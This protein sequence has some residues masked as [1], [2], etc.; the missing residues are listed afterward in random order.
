MNNQVELRLRY[1]DDEKIV[2]ELVEFFGWVA[3]PYVQKEEEI[4]A[5]AWGD[6]IVIVLSIVGEWAAERYVLDPLANRAEEWWKGITS[7]WRK[8]KSRRRF[9]VIVEFKHDA[10]DLE[11]EISDTSD[12]ETLKQVWSYVGRAYQV[13]Q[14]ARNQGVFL[15]KVRIL[16]DGT[17]DVLVIGYES[18]RPRYTIDLDTQALQQIEPLTDESEDTSVQLWVIEQLIK[19]LDYLQALAVNGYDV[20]KEEIIALKRE[21]EAKK[22][23]LGAS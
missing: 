23:K 16:P 11:V 17:Q 18:N 8:S 12:E 3:T 13:C 6:T 14:N 4:A 22:A 20:S 7:T 5:K 1:G 2:S 21:I 19:R 10:S 9:N 15:N